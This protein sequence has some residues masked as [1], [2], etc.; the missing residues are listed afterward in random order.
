[1]KLDLDQS[2]FN[3]FNLIFMGFMKNRFVA[4]AFAWFLGGIGLNNFYTGHITSGVVDILFCW[5]GIPVIVNCIR[6]CCYL[7]QD[8][9]EEFNRKFCK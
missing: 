8:G 5:T 2:I 3:I 7:W 6:A 9:D 1:M 4:A